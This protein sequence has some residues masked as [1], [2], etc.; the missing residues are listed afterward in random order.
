MCSIQNAQPRALRQS[1][2]LSKPDACCS[3]T[4][5]MY[6]LSKRLPVRMWNSAGL[7]LCDS[8][9]MAKDQSGHCAVKQQHLLPISAD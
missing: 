4:C 1:V 3:L 9:C 5:L 8:T 7:R 2:K 6:P